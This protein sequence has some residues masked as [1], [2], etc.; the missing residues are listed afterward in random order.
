VGE[1][2][3]SERQAYLEVDPGAWLGEAADVEG[4]VEFLRG[5]CRKPCGDELDNVVV[6]RENLTWL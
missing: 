4:F 3:A 6:G 5:R 1:F 2:V